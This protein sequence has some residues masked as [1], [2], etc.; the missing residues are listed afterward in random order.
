MDPDEAGQVSGYLTELGPVFPA[1]DITFIRAAGTKG[2]AKTH[3][4]TE[5]SKKKRIDD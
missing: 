1:L 5:D 4:E 2:D 3:D